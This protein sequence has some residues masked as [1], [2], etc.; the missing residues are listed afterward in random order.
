[1]TSCGRFGLSLTGHSCLAPY[2]DLVLVRPCRRQLEAATC[3]GDLANGSSDC[4]SVCGFD[5]IEYAGF[6]THRHVGRLA[7]YSGDP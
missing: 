1:M 4:H 6:S 7:G 2:C 3:I 5:Q